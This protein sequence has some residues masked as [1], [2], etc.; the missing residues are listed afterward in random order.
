MLLGYKSF[1]SPGGTYQNGEKVGTV[2]VLPP[3]CC[4]SALHKRCSP[5]KAVASYVRIGALAGIK[6][7]RASPCQAKSG[8]CV[9]QQVADL[10][11]EKVISAEPYVRAFAAY[12][13][14]NM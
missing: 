1:D 6:L 7:G 12:C 13:Q 10:D 9:C 14:C 2:V 3:L 11:R 5:S 8:S 4:T